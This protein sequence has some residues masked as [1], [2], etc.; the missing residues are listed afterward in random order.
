[1]AEINRVMK[2]IEE[3]TNQKLQAQQQHEKELQEMAEQN[4]NTRQQEMLQYESDQNERD[5]ENKVRVAE[6][7]AAGRSGGVDVNQNE[8]N[9]YLDTLKYLNTKDINDQKV[10]LAKDK[11]IRDEII[12]Q[13]Q[14]DLKEKELRTKE[15]IAAQQLAVAKENKNKY[16]K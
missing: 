4:A 6:I 3:K 14:L 15:R 8:Q 1:M 9:D 11:Q 13:R 2:S 12:S 5:R 7:T 10:Q 16:D